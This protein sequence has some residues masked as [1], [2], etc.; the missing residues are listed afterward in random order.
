VYSNCTRRQVLKVTDSLSFLVN[1]KVSGVGWWSG[2]LLKHKAGKKGS[3][4]KQM[5]AE[6]GQSTAAPGQ[7]H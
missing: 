2:R 6:R 7:R 5:G 1:S 4:V 3:P